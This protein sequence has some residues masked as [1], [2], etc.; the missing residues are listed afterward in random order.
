M[1]SRSGSWSTTAPPEK[2]LISMTADFPEITPPDIVIGASSIHGRGVFATRDF[3]EGE[4]VEICPV[5]VVSEEEIEFLDKTELTNYRYAW[6]DGA[7]LAL[8]YGSLYNHSSKANAEHCRSGEE[9]T[10]MEIVAVREI[11]AGEEITIS[12]GPSDS[13]WFDPI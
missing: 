3:Q 9:S 5:L 8:G 7:A 13:L 4:V 10:V 12:Y 1:V 11:L 6:G 2:N